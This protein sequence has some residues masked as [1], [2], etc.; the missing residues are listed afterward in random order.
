V[1]AELFK[2]PNCGSQYKLVR[3]EAEPDPSHGRMECRHCG[4]PL[5]GREGRFILKYFLI[6][7]PRRAI[8][9]LWF[10]RRPTDAASQIVAAPL[11]SPRRCRQPIAAC[12]MMQTNDWN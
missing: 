6:D 2:C 11:R 3:V 10:R 4:G 5:N 8:A 12:P 1:A 7:R 9:V